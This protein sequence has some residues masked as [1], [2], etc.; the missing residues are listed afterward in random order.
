MFLFRDVTLNINKEVRFALSQIHGIG[1]RKANVITSKMGLC[2]PFF[3][4]NMNNF[5]Y[6]L[7]VSLLRLL[8]LSDV[9]IKRFID[10]RINALISINCVRGLRHKLCLPVHGQR[11]RTNASTQRIKRIRRQIG[12]FIKIKKLNK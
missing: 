8:V 2:Y 3:F 12:T 1:L 11:T 10:Y 6:G 7:I 5:N 9:R 4:N